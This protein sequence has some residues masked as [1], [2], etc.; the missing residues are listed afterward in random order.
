MAA[1][2]ARTG[3]GATFRYGWNWSFHLCVPGAHPLRV[4][5]A[6]I[7]AVIAGRQWG[8]PEADR[9]QVASRGVGV[10]LRARAG[11]Q[12]V[13]VGAGELVI[14][15]LAVGDGLLGLDLWGAD[16]LHPQVRA[17]RV[18]CLGGEHPGVGPAGG[19]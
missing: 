2:R 9:V 17:V 1:A 7:L 18:R 5:Y 11:L 19:A 3:R 8:L 16:V 12:L 14:R 13:H 4:R 15:R 6:V 10:V